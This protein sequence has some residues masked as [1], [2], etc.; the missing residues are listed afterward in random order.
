MANQIFEN[1]LRES[2]I[3]FNEIQRK[4][5]LISFLRLLVGL[6]ILITFYLFLR[7][8]DFTYLWSALALLLVFIGLIRKFAQLSFDKKLAQAKV[9]INQNELDFLRDGRLK[10]EG[11]EEFIDPNHPY[12]YDL[13]FFGNHSLFQVM[14]RTETFIGKQTL[15][16]K[17]LR[18]SNQENILK[19]QQAIQEL[20]SETEWRQEVRAYGKIAEDNHEVYENIQQWTKIESRTLSKM[21]VIASYALPVIFISLLFVNSIFDKDWDSL[22]VL[23]FLFNVGVVGSEAKNIKKE[24]IGSTKIDRTLKNYSQ[25]F[26]QIENKDFESIALQDLKKRL[27]ASGR[28]ASAEVRKLSQLFDQL[29]SINN[30]FGAALFNGFL[31]FHLHTLRGF[32]R[33]KSENVSVIM[34]WLEVIGEVEFLNSGANFSQVNPEFI[35]PELNDTRHLAFQQL[36]HPL[37]KKHKRVTSDVEFSQQ[38]FI[39]LTGSNMSGKSTFLRSLGVN[40]VLAGMGAPVCAS[41]ANVHPMPVLVSM[42]V[43]DSLNDNESFF[44]AEVKS[45]KEIMVAAEK[46]VSFVL[47]DEILRGTNSDDKRTGTVEVLKKIISK[48]AIGALATHDLKVCETAAEY[49]NQLVNKCFEVEIVDNELFFDYKLREGVCKNKSATFLMKKMGVI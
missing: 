10:F 28:L 30:P 48:N 35:F 45:L 13:D 44:F 1:L 46:E 47:L 34:D 17:L 25:I 40:M 19:T 4:T 20:T 5:R 37:L 14:N 11:G 32:Q 24:L 36:G 6:G 8:Q 33:W 21:M 23:F 29:E 39:I 49:P 38:N 27:N 16:Q 31:L 18:K 12:A 9:D 42:R 22:L 15:A 3:Q 43:S 26:A 2:Q 7:R 41:K